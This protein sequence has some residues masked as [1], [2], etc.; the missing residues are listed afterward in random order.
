MSTAW[1]YFTP[2][3]S[4]GSAEELFDLVPNISCNI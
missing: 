3:H 2:E 4:I 1:K